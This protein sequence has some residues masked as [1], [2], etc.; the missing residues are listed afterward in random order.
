M[1]STFFATIFIW[2]TKFEIYSTILKIEIRK[3][4]T[5]LKDAF[6]VELLLYYYLINHDYSIILFTKT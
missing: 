1:F 5:D 4:H 2:W 3:E 6:R